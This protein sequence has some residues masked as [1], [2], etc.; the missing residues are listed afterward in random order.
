MD[1][2]HAAASGL[3]AWAGAGL[4]GTL[5]GPGATQHVSFAISA[6]GLVIGGA[7]LSVRYFSAGATTVATGFALLVLAESHALGPQ[8]AVRVRYLRRPR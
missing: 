3:V 6:V 7:L 1:T 2:R 8:E 4:V 5:A